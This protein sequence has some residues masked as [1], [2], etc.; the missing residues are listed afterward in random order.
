MAILIENLGT[1]VVS[2]IL[3]FII[4]GILFDLFRK[5]KGTDANCGGSCG[6]CPQGCACCSPGEGEKKP[7][8]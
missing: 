6:S 7:G 1:I 5:N 2:I 3:L 4:I 8:K